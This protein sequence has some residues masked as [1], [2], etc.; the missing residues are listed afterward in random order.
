MDE[1]EGGREEGGLGGG[2]GQDRVEGPRNYTQT[3]RERVRIWS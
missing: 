2:G 1:G 3:R